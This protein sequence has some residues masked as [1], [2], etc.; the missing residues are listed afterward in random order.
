VIFLDIF[1]I[2]QLTK[3]GCFFAF[4]WLNLYYKK[5]KIKKKYEKKNFRDGSNRG[6]D[7]FCVVQ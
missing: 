6:I 1:E 2:L 7:G 3:K 4:F 5:W